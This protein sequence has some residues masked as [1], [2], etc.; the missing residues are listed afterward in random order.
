MKTQAL[1]LNRDGWSRGL[2]VI[3]ATSALA[4]SMFAIAAPVRAATVVH[5][6][7]NFIGTSS[8]TFS[9]QEDDCGPFG[10]TGSGVV[11]HFILNQLDTDTPAGT[12]CT[13]AGDA[14]LVFTW[15]PP[16]SFSTTLRYVGPL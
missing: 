5:I 15:N 1:A 6:E 9:E 3:A 12:P 10:T 8:A 2:M 14:I 13:N 11:W 7:S 16:G 4:L